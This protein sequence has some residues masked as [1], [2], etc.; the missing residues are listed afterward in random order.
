MIPPHETPRAAA[1][2]RSRLVT[3]DLCVPIHDSR[4]DKKE[5][6]VLGTTP[7]GS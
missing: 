1:L 5:K 6:V 4:R 2:T 7:G 3:H